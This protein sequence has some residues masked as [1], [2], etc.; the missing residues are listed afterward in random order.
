M[1]KKIVTMA[2]TT[3]MAVSSLTGC[4]A[5]N[6]SSSTE[7]VSTTASDATEHADNEGTSTEAGSSVETKELS[8]DLFSWQVSIDGVIYTLPC[9][10]SE[11][12]KNGWELFV[13]EGTEDNRILNAHCYGS[14]N[15]KKGE[16]IITVW[17][18]NT[19]DEDMEYSKASVVEVELLLDKIKSD[20]EVVF[21]NN[22]VASKSITR[23]EVIEKYGEPTDELK[24]VE[25]DPTCALDY[26]HQ[27]NDD[28]AHKY[29]DWMIMFTEEG[30]DVLKIV[31]RNFK[32]GTTINSVGRN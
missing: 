14:I 1:K 28:K 22:L 18:Q 10:F 9:E 32:Q 24:A 19:T 13:E 2:L 29:K 20:M 15:I 6:E 16:D 12:E 21:P 30:G 8:A 23:D 4:S 27:D 25:E 5:A 7:P 31:Y 11:F 17:L 26:Q 3:A